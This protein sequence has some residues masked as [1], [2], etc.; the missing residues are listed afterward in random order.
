MDAG[1]FRAEWGGLAQAMSQ[2]AAQV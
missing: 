2:K 1:L